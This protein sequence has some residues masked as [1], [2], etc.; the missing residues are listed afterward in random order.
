MDDELSDLEIE[1]APDRVADV[2]VDLAGDLGD[3][4]AQGDV[5]VELE[6]EPV[7]EA[8]PEAGPAEVQAV[9]EAGDGPAG[10]AGDA[11]RSERRIP[12]DIDDRATGDERAAGRLIGWHA[13]DVLLAWRV[14]RRPS[15][16]AGGRVV[17]YR[18]RSGSYE[19]GPSQTNPED[20]EWPAPAPSAARH[21]WP[22][23]TP[24]R[25]G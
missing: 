20:H 1:G 17:S 10:E 22:V 4:H 2:G 9:E 8:Q 12:D 24:S 15:L 11:V 21:P 13:G 7:V 18:F 5:E 25:R 23:S 19:L 3:R 6:V 16:G 14:G